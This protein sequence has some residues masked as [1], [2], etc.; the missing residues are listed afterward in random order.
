MLIGH[1][2]RF[3]QQRIHL[4]IAVERAVARQPFLVGF[5]PVVHE[6]VG[7]GEVRA[8]VADGDVVVTLADTVTHG[9]VGQFLKFDVDAHRRQ[10][11]LYRQRYRLPVGVAYRIQEI[12]R[13]R[14]VLHRRQ[15]CFGLVRILAILLRGGVVSPHAFRDR[16]THLFAVTAENA[17][18]H[19]LV[20]H[21]VGNGA[22]QINLIQRR[23]AVVEI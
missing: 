19:A 7:V 3:F 10:A 9:G 8:P 1:R 13:S 6:H 23:F 2:N 16:A 22:A 14:F 17:L 5:E 20:I 21:R 15:C 4:R 11:G 18:H 12:E